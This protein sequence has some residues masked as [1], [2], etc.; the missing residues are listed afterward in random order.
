VTVERIKIGVAGLHFGRHIA[1]ED[2]LGEKGA[3]YFELAAVCDRLHEKADEW[4]ERFGV[5]AYYDIDELIADPEIPVIG[6]FIGPVGRAEWIRKIIRAGKDVMTTKPFELDPETALEVLREAEDLGRT[7]HLNSP[8]PLLAPEMQQ[9]SDWI[10]KGELGQPVACRAD[11]W[12]S[13]REE[14]DGTWYDDPDQCPVAPIFRLGIYV[15]SDIVRF[16]GAPEAV[17]VTAS[18]VFTKRPT[19]DNAQL[20]VLFK[21][22]AIASIFASFCVGDREPYKNVLSM[23]FENGSVYRNVGP[24]TEADSEMSVVYVAN[25]EKKVERAQFDGHSGEYQWDALYRA[26][27]GE[28]LEE[29]IAPEEVAAG[30]QILRAM[31]KAELSGK[32]EKV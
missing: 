14:P 10:E 21:S 22:G 23:N 5:K 19:A 26:V 9:I 8:S 3:P 31:R 11:V 13:Y 24:R 29:R 20:N 17:Q 25:G 6:L 27:K 16:F 1:E 7:V 15:I 12:A 32:M 18:R 28:K 30:V 2:I 4:A